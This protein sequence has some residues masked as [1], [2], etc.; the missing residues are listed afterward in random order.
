MSNHSTFATV[1][2]MEVVVVVPTRTN[3]CGAPGRLPSLTYKNS[4][5]YRPDAR[6]AAQSAVSKHWETEQMIR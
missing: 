3:T 2:L 6:L 5:F 1:E 4:Y